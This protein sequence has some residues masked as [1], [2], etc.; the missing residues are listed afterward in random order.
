[1]LPFMKKI[2]LCLFVTLLCTTSYSQFAGGTGKYKDQIF[3]LTFLPQSEGGNLIEWP[4]MAIPWEDDAL[5]RQGRY[6]WMITDNIR[7]DANISN[8]NGDLY[9]KSD[10]WGE[11]NYIYTG[12]SLNHFSTSPFA[13]STVNFD[14][15]AVIETLN[16]GVWTPV[17]NENQGLIVA[18]AEGLAYSDVSPDP[19]EY[20]SFRTPSTTQLYVIDGMTYID[21]DYELALDYIIE[22]TTDNLTNEKIIRIYPADYDAS[23]WFFSVIYAKGTTTLREIEMKGGGVTTIALGV[24]TPTIKSTAPIT[25]GEAV[26]L[27][28]I[29]NFDDLTPLQ[30]LSNLSSFRTLNEEFPDINFTSITNF[31]HTPLQNIPKLFTDV[32]APSY[33]V[34]IPALNDASAISYVYAWIDINGDGV[35]S[36]DE[37]VEL[38]LPANS[39][40]QIISLEFPQA[41]YTGATPKHSY[42]RI[43][44]TTEPLTNT[45]GDPSIIDTRSYGYSSNGYVFDQPIRITES[46]LPIHLISFDA[47]NKSS[48]NLLTWKT[49]NEVNNSHFEILKSTNGI[50][51]WTS[52]G[53]IEAVQNSTNTIEYSFEDHQVTSGANYYRL[54]QV[55]IDGQSTLYSIVSIKNEIYSTTVEVYP[56]PFTNGF[57]IKMN[58][59]EREQYVI[60]IYSIDGKLMYTRAQTLVEGIRLL[61]VS[62]LDNL[63]KG[64]YILNIKKGNKNVHSQMLIKN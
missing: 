37:S 5:I 40:A 26:H 57:T 56:V 61:Q 9:F 21:D 55:D 54:K 60:E 39:G 42:L 10:D 50:D 25:Y 14:I 48:Y 47:V 33:D 13:G 38:T 43:R 41:M 46:T 31:D 3:W 19:L 36:Q 2:L 4:D 35:F 28:E 62:Q 22:Q 44:V 29:A 11:F 23:E 12:L 16:N 30:G 20:I 18:D 49:N 45:N 17:I 24:I 64:T 53:R 63:A 59:E 58:V 8:I 32:S 6:V 7:V 34:T 51:Q 15:T 52:I 1:M 27:Q